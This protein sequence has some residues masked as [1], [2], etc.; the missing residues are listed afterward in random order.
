[1]RVLLD[2]SVLVRAI[3]PGDPLLPQ[4]A[5]RIEELESTGFQPCVAPQVV[6]EFWVVT[7]RPTA[8]NGRG[9]STAEAMKDVRAILELFPCDPDPP[10]LLAKWLDL[11]EHHEVLGKP[12]HDARLVAYMIEHEIGSLMTL[13][14]AHFRRFGIDVIEP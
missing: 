13:N 12:S 9:F 14:A 8:A 2:T 6:Y 5:K 3:V 10:T 1:L 7:T 11:C 4:V